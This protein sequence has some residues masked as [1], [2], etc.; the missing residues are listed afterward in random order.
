MNHHSEDPE[1]HA[2][3]A[4]SIV[5]HCDVVVIGGSAA[6][7]AATLQLS[8]QR[9]SVIVVDD[10]RPRNAP[11]A[12]MH[13]FLGREGEPPGDLLAKGR[14]EVRGYGAEVLNG[15]AVQVSRDGDSFAVTLD[16]GAVLMARR[17]LVATGMSDDLPKVEGLAEH[18]GRDVIHCP[19]CHGYEFRDQR[20]VQ[21]VTHPLGL[22]ATPMLRQLT[23]QLT[24][25]IAEGVEVPEE[26]SSQLVAAGVQLRTGV[27][28]TRVLEDSTGRVSGLELNDGAQLT[29]DVI[30]V[31]PGFHP[32]VEALAEL[33]LR[34]EL[35]ATGMGEVIAVDPTGATAIEGVFAAGSVTDPS[36]QVL[37]AAAEGSRVG[38]AVAVSL[39]NQD[40]SAAA[41]PSGSVTDW[42]QRYS[43]ESLWSGNPNGSLVAEATQ[44]PKGRALDVGAGEGGDAVWLAEQG[45]EVTAT[46]ISSRALQRIQAAADQRGLTVTCQLADAN[47]WEPFA[48]GEFDLV[49]AAY[50]S[51]P[52]TPDLRGVKNIL[53][54]VA[55]GGSL[56]ILSHDMEAMRN[57]SHSHVPFDPGAYVHAD[58]FAQALAAS[59]DWSLEVDAKRARPAGS[60][61]AD[62]H[63]DDR[64]LRARRLH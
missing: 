48:P 28:A 14:E 26:Q 47:G 57:R 63:P 19:F 58:D 22:H 5:R 60:V 18:W 27:E 59:P 40:L 61:T 54:A 38:A 24:V 13:S 23:A 29:A 32:R 16:G 31:G 30:L 51:I 62:Q 43:G 4:P 6:G 44:L 50:A 8:R 64:V 36:Q 46:D 11:A 53:A 2:H 42:D 15:R 55:P 52:R 39:A 12:H 56:L 1:S 37:V 41:R 20:M 35:H 21:L 3:T 45:W 34:P 10:G 25:V 33:G 17:I 7:L 49:T 9:R